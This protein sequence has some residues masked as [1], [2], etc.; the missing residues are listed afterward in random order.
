MGK[1]YHLMWK[2]AQ[3][4]EWLTICRS[5]SALEATSA[6]A[7]IS[8]NPKVVQR[9]ELRDAGGRETLETIWDASWVEAS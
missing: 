6:A 1:P 2:S 3:T 5:Y 4:G 8:R 9:I 7:M